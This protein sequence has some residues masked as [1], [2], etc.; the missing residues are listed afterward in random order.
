MVWSGF[1]QWSRGLN[2]SERRQ[3]RW[4]VVALIALAGGLTAAA[5][6]FTG[7]W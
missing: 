3:R 2:G 6:R 4:R 1:R 7:A 5:L